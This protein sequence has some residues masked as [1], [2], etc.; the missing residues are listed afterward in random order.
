MTTVAMPQAM[1]SMVSAVRRRL[2]RMALVGFLKQIAEH[3]LFPITSTP[4]GALPP[5]AAWPPCAPD[6]DRRPHR[7]GSG[8]QS[9]AIADMGTSFGGS[10]PP[11]PSIVPSSAIRPAASPMPISP[12]PSVRSS[13]SRKNWS[14]MLRLVAPRAL[15]NPISRVRSLTVTSMML[16]TPMAPRASV[17]MPTVPRNMFM[18]SKMV[19]TI[20]DCWI[21]SQPS[22]A[23]DRCQSKAVIAGDDL[24][25]V[26]L[27]QQVL[28][29]HA[30]LIVDV[31]NRVLV[32]FSLERESRSPSPGR[33]CSCEYSA[34]Y[35]RRGRCVRGCR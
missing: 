7:P 23:S 21:V 22:K 30:R 33:E 20:L 32:V 28:S 10:N 14:R 26:F 1:P 6:R 16:M 35:R 5:V 27:G 24:V 18:A 12:L 34:R 25:D 11:G 15:R 3:D 9:P 13:P 29:G 2:C 31:G 4:A 19:P 17:T 8:C